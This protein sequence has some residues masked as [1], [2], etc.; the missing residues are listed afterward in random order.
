MS[1]RL[2]RSGIPEST[3]FIKELGD[4]CTTGTSFERIRRNDTEQ[5]RNFLNLKTLKY[6]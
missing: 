1:F 2:K 5:I 4:S 3:H 6:I